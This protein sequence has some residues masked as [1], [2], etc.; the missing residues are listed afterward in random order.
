MKCE[1]WRKKS[2]PDGNRTHNLLLRR[3]LL[4]PIELRDLKV[5][6]SVEFE[7]AVT[8]KLLKSDTHTCTLIVGVAGFEPATSWSQTMR[9]DRTT[10]HPELNFFFLAI[11]FL[12]CGEG[13]IR[14]LGTVSR[15]TV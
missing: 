10:L 7:C 2:D 15:T 6:L 11:Y 4:Y 14:T 1:V 5:S 8:G 3:Q 13:G 12:T 9:D